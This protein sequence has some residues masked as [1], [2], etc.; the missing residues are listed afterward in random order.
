VILG[1][2][3][4]RHSGEFRP[5]WSLRPGW[6][7]APAAGEPRWLAALD[8]SVAAAVAQD[9]E[10][11]SV[12]LAAVFVVIAVAIYVPA[13]TRPTLVLSIV[14][15]TAIWVIGENFGGILTG[16]ATD[17]DTGPLLV[18]LAFAF[19]PLGSARSAA[20]RRPLAASHGQVV[21]AASPM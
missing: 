14:I 12:L 20:A 9:G 7:T 1:R 18:L 17:P 11:I 2:G 15:A 5:S 21:G 4:A 16:Q 8:Q 3:A 10:I 6:S 13:A 19:W